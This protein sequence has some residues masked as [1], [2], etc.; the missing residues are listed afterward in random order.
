MLSVGVKFPVTE[1]LPIIV[2]LS[3][4]FRVIF[5]F[6]TLLFIS[7]TLKVIPLRSP[8]AGVPHTGVPSAPISFTKSP[9]PQ[10]VPN[11][12]VSVVFDACAVKLT[13]EFAAIRFSMLVF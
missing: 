3:F 8:P 6:V 11:K 4:V 5:R 9:A 13:D 7:E 12:A 1:K 2:W 10:A